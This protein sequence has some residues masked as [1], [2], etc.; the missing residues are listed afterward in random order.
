M[1]ATTFP[2]GAPRVRTMPGVRRVLLAF[3]PPDGGVAEH[4]LQL[5]RLLLEHG[6]EP[7]VAGPAEA[8]TYP[9]LAEA[10][11]RVVRLDVDRGLDPRRY[12]R[13]TAALTRLLGDERFDLVH[14]HSSK[15]G[16]IARLAA[17][18]ARVPA[19]Y[20]PHCYAFVG[21]QPAARRLVAVAVERA[22]ARVTDATICVAEDERRTAAGSQIGDP[23]RL[24]VVRNG[25]PA[26]RDDL[27][28]DPELAEHAGG[29]PLAAVVTALRPQ[30]AVDVF[31]AAAPVILERVP[32]ARLAVVGDGEQRD[33]LEAQA[34]ALGLGDRL[35]F[36]PF[37]AP[38]ARQLRSVDVFV[39]PSLWEAFPI[40]VLEALACGVPQVATDV[41]GTRE[42]IVDGE[43]GLLCR[44]GDPADLADKVVRLLSDPERRARMTA[45][46]RARHRDAFTLERM[47]AETAAVY[48]SVVA[49]R[50]LRRP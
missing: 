50:Y 31:V 28:P 13:A 23:S 17:R 10:G 37:Q 41:G 43:T 42:A 16:A 11:T 39:L 44:P 26:C 25:A 8:V 18:R 24:R 48:D 49:A 12:G 5:A 45:A 46:S 9:A 1:D 32:G 38:A 3:E 34:R 27:E 2:G 21:P 47:A 15:A 20:T 30:K 29:G 35:R 14:A 6:W 19:V 7:T 40:S 4:V 22:L 36:L 33:E